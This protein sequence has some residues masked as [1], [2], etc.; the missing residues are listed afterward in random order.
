MG[1]GQSKKI[2]ESRP[3]RGEKALQIQNVSRKARKGRQA[4]KIETFHHPGVGRDPGIF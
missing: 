1:A 4:E 2:S 3:W